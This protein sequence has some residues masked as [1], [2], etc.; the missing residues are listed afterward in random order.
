VGIR[1]RSYNH[2]CF[3]RDSF[4][5]ITNIAKIQVSLPNGNKLHVNLIGTIKICEFFFNWM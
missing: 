3:D 2:I 4:F 1:Q 5:S